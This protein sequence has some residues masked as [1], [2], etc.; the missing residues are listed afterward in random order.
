MVVLGTFHLFDA[1]ELIVLVM[2]IYFAQTHPSNSHLKTLDN[3][4]K[5]ILL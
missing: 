1:L 2:L 5:Q 3:V 4:A